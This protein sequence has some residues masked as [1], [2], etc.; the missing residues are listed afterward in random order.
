ML[1]QK[2]RFWRTES[3][4]KKKEAEQ[5]IMLNHDQLIID[6]TGQPVNGQVWDYRIDA[7]EFTVN[8]PLA[9]E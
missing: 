1:I 8:I 4:K 5:G 6:A 2:V 7:F 9:G 3:A